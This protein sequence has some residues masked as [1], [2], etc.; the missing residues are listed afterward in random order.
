MDNPLGYNLKFIGYRRAP[1]NCLPSRERELFI[2]ELA[3]QN[4]EKITI[5]CYNRYVD[6]FLRF[7]LSE[8]KT[9]AVNKIPPEAGLRF[10]QHVFRDPHIGESTCLYKLRS[11][12]K[13]Y[14]WMLEE[15]IVKHNPF[16]EIKF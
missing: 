5:R 11:V 9:T 8:Y 7:T 13:W 4:L 6:E 15:K 12:N 16:A 3:N 10:Q 2:A 1:R 14:R